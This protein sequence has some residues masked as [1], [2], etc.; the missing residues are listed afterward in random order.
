M[1]IYILCVFCQT[2]FSLQILRGELESIHGI[3]SIR[4]L[5]AVELDCLS[6]LT[7]LE[8]LA[9][10]PDLEYLEIGYC[11]DI[12]DWDF[13]LELKKMKRLNISANS[14]KDYPPQNILDRLREKNIVVPLKGT[15]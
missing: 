1:I 4:S 3:S 14:Y 12:K 10:L 7:A 8:E 5:H 15:N 2:L 6:K 9:E 13:L 11:K